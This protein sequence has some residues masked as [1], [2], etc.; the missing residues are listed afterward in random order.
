MPLSGESSLSSELAGV[1]VE[2]LREMDK[3]RRIDH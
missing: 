3:F 2:I 1:S